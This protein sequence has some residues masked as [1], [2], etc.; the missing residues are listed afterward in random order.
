[1]TPT[2]KKV[3]ASL[4]W[5]VLDTGSHSVTPWSKPKK[6]IWRRSSKIRATFEFMFCIL[7]HGHIA[8][9]KAEQ[10][11]TFVPPIAVKKNLI[12]NYNCKL[13]R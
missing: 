8:F 13:L 10:R 1:V 7:R 6:R 4:R 2:P 11:R 5:A 12:S 9:Y 3:S